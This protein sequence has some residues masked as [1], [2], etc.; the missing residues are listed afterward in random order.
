MGRPA[1]NT[2]FNH[3]NDKITF[4]N[5]PPNR[6]RALFGKSFED[7][8]KSFGYDDAHAD[9]ITNILLPDIL[10]YNYKS[11]AG[12][13]NGRKLTDDV[14]DIELALV[15]NGQITTDMVGP[16]TDYLNEFP[17]VGNPHV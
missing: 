12:F 6:Q 17:F 3:G 4:N 13:L 8:L 10:T 2:V 7:T 5:T 16:H 1:I 11:S 9:A 14:I 15:T